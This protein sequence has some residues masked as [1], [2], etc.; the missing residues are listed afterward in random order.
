MES[1][2]G[3]LKL[4]RAV[5]RGGQLEIFL[6]GAGAQKN[7]AA[8][9]FGGVGPF[10][11][12]LQGTAQLLEC[13]G[14]VAAEAACQLEFAGRFFVVPGF[15]GDEA[16]MIVTIRRFGVHLGERR[17]IALALLRRPCCR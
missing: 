7:G 16:K 11:Q 17:S 5:K 6:A 1:G 14:E 15:G 12:F 3:F 8:M 9:G 4:A 13:L 10:A 2:D